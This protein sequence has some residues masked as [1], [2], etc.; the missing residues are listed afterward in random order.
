MTDLTH[1]AGLDEALNEALDPAIHID[2]RDK[3]AW[4]SEVDRVA[5]FKAQCRMQ[6]PQVRIVAVPNAAKR[7][8]AAQ[9]QVKREGLNAGFPDMLVFSGRKIAFLEWKNGTSK[10]SQAQ[11]DWLNWLHRNGFACGVFRRAD[12]AMAW[13]K[14]GGF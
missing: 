9:R 4:L 1:F 2:E 13:L 11:V 10:P 8:F 5:Q 6:L 3:D 14:Q 12:S 7:G